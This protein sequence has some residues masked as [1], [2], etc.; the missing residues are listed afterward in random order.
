MKPIKELH[1]EY[2]E[3]L[4]NKLLKDP[5]FFI[6]NI[7]NEFK[8]ASYQEE[9]VNL[10]NENARTNLCAFRTSGK[11]EICFV[12]YPIYLAYTKPRQ[13]LILI[14]KSMPQ[15]TE[16]IK[17]IKEKIYYSEVLRT[18]IPSNRNASWSRTEIELKNGSRIACKP[19]NENIRGYHVNFCGCDE[20]GEY[21]DQ[22]IYH[23][24]IVP[25]TIAHKGRIAC[26]GTPTSDIDLIHELQKNPA[27]KSVVYPVWIKDRNFFEERYPG[28]KIIKE[29]GRYNIYN[30]KNE[31]FDSYDIFSFSREL[32]CQ[33][34]SEDDRLFPF[35]LIKDS[36]MEGM[37]F[38]TK[39]EGRESYY[40]G[41]DFA[42]SANTGADYTS[43]C[44]GKIIDGKK[45]LV[46][47]ERYKGL[48]YAAQKERLRNLNYLFNPIQ[49]LADEKSFGQ[50]FIQ[51]LRAEKVPIHGFRFD[52]GPK[53]EAIASL[54]SDFEDGSIEIPRNTI[55]LNT[56]MKVDV[57]VKELM[58]YGVKYDQ[59][60]KTIKFEGIGTHDDCVDAFSLMCFAMRHSG[61]SSYAINRGSSK[62]SRS[63]LFSKT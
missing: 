18:A 59:V 57:L 49:V 27:Y 31:L 51:E 35:S 25:T 30:T 63:A 1:D 10:I 20:I 23:R 47:M 45:R 11:T 41:A 17:R 39:R 38:E 52:A 40:V 58:S 56:K 21:K 12:D 7:I 54:R 4:R 62:H 24:S 14:S 37:M 61:F 50:A 29:K 16:L 9:F 19:Y 5:V 8:L 2:K 6:N 44:V 3:E 53:Q 15:S 55:D 43:F 28:W 48:G 42:L 33:P 46:K 26:A 22:N 13:H 32:L 60:K 36:F 34:L